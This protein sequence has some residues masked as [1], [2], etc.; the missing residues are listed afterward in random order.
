M[1]N[2]LDTRVRGVNAAHEYAASIVG[3]LRERFRPLVGQKVLKNDGTLMAK[4]VNLLPE[5]PD[6]RFHRLHVYKHTSDYSLAWMVKTCEVD[7][8]HAYY[9]EVGVYVGDL[10][11]GVLTKITEHPFT[12]RMDH[13]AAE[14][15]EKRVAFE[16][17]RRAFEDARSE[18]H[19]FGEYDR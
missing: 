16:A 7:N 13:T 18:L 2:V 14:V 12:G 9:Y 19:P 3:V 6:S 8:G 1:N 15:L 5:M 11:N 4:Y 17:A 10:T